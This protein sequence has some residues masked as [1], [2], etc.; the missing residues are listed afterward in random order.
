[1]CLPFSI[2]APPNTGLYDYETAKYFL[3]FILLIKMGTKST[4]CAISLEI[5]V[6][7]KHI[8]QD[9]VSS[10]DISGYIKRSEYKLEQLK[11]STYPIGP[12]DYICPTC[13][14]RIN[15]IKDVL[16]M[17]RVLSE[18]NKGDVKILYDYIYVDKGTIAFTILFSPNFVAKLRWKKLKNVLKVFTLYKRFVNRY[19]TPPN[20]QGYKQSMSHFTN[21]A[22]LSNIK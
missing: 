11:K 6:I 10:C 15:Y 21:L 7:R 18:N 17:V 19:Y 9:I 12:S 14:K 1:M 3:K 5:D 16:P 13:C 4:K 20:G 8:E 2:Y 22:S